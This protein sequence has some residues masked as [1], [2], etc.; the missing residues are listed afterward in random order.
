MA[1]GPVYSWVLELLR[2]CLEV[3]EGD[4][5]IEGAHVKENGDPML[6]SWLVPVKAAVLAPHGGPQVWQS[7]GH[8]RG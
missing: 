5:V 3:L 7:I 8:G 1:L 4:G 6:A 2:S